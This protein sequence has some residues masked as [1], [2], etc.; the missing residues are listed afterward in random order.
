MEAIPFSGL[1]LSP[2]ALATS[3]ACRASVAAVAS[4]PCSPASREATPR[5]LTTA[6]GWRSVGRWSRETV[7]SAARASAGRPARYRLR[8]ERRRGHP[9][10]LGRSRAGELGGPAGGLQDRADV[11]VG[12]HGTGHGGLERDRR[13]PAGNRC[14]G[15]AAVGDGQ[16]ALHLLLGDAAVAADPHLGHR[17]RRRGGHDL[18][19]QPV[20]PALHGRDPSPPRER[21]PVAGDQVGGPLV[22]A[23]GAGVVDGRLDVAGVLVEGGRPPVQQR[24]QVGL[25]P[26]QL[27]AQQLGEQVVV[28]VPVAVVVEGDQEQVGLF[29]LGQQLGRP[30]RSP[31]PRRTAAP[32]AAPGPRCGP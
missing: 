17:N 12:E 16:P 21:Q 31:A 2:P 1:K 25:A 6:N 23:G 27:Q 8:A 18:V 10:R 9:A 7:L 24:D 32:T 26:G 4:S 15:V 11:V 14:A 29:Q 5:M 30:A 3:I 20:Q 13:G 19:G 28:A 22:V